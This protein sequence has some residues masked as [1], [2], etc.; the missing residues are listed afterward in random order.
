M[1]ARERL[2]QAY[3]RTGADLPY[4]DPRPAHR[5]EMEGYFWRFTHVPTGTVVVAL[6][7]VNQRG[8]G[9]WATVALAVHPGGFVRAAALAG[10][11]ADPLQ[12]GVRAG[13][14]TP[15][16]DP[17]GGRFHGGERSVDVDLGPDAQLTA[18][19]REVFPWPRRPL[20]GG[21]LASVVPFLNQYWHPHVLGGSADLE[22]RAG[23]A[24]LTLAGA[25]VY[26][27]KNWGAG[28]PPRWWWGQAQGFDRDDVCLAF[29]GGHLALGP[30]GVDVSGV[31]VRVGDDIVRLAPPLA[32]VR[33]GHNPGVG[34]GRWHLRG[35]NLRDEVELEGDPAGTEPHVLPVPVPSRGENV[36]TDFEHL[37]ARVH[38]CVRRRGRTLYEGT[39]ALAGL[40]HGSAPGR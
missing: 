36:F 22:V 17:G 21:G 23:D 19:L 12:L 28:F 3:R 31:V 18:R 1:T 16:G 32:L 14:G 6:C 27:E 7:G 39:S 8:E 20:A 25:Q 40:E 2:A 29:S 15:D 35:R 9:R 34:G 10:A 24:T 33:S 38:L 5:A 26:A 30:L 4:A 13:A 37:A 11:E